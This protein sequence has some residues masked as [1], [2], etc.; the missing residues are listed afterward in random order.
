MGRS[1]I[2]SQG[3]LAMLNLN[4]H[5]IQR[6][7]H[8]P[9]YYYQKKAVVDT[10]D[11]IKW[12]MWEKPCIVI[13]TGG[14]KTKVTGELCAR[15]IERKRRALFLAPTR[16]LVTQPRL[17]FEDDFGCAATI[18]MGSLKADDSPMVFAS[19]A[20]MRNRVAKGLWRPDEFDTVIFDES[21]GIL[22]E[23]HQIVADYFGKGGAKIIGC[24]ATPRRGDKKDLMKFF[25]GLSFDKPIQELFKEGFLICPTIVHEPLGVVIQHKGKGEIDDE[26]INHAIEPYLGRAADIVMKY[27]KGRCGLSFLP[28]RKT[29]LIFRDMLRERG[30]RAEYVA[31]AGGEAGV[32]E[33]EQKEIKH[34]LMMGNIDMVCNAQI[35]GMGVDIRP[36]NLLVDLRPTM[37]WPS[38]MQKWGRMTRTWDPDAGY[39]KHEFPGSKWPKKTDA[40]LLDFC[41]ETS[42]HSMIQ[43]PAVMVA[44]DDEEVKAITE[45]LVKGGGGDLMEAVKGAAADR[46]AT[47]LQRLKAMQ[48]GTGITMSAMEFFLGQK[49]T[50]LY[51]YQPT[52]QVEMGPVTDDQKHT[53]ADA[54]IDWE[55]MTCRGQASKMIDMIADRRMK[56]LATAKQCKFCERLGHKDPWSLTFDEARRWITQRT[57]K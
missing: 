32:D 47:L 2:V 35:W 25:D 53:L 1:G 9:P 14:G 57:G 10:E 49:R 17:S 16:E 24:T 23:G 20:T 12:D 6:N 34:N 42:N 15:A 31:G 13:P 21:H 50:D 4:G 5:H 51:D 39:A 18:E 54:G 41:M 11:K 46:N 19:V 8:K 52:N 28:L 7:P 44:K 27:A 38:A 37:S 48:S 33:E 36:C 30:L 55:T 43:R 26:E 45:I 40:I 3:G 29:A 56:G 22:A